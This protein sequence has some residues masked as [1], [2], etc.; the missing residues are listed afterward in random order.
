MSLPGQLY[1]Y[2]SVLALSAGAG[3]GVAGQAW[4]WGGRGVAGL[5]AER[6]GRVRRR[7]GTRA[8]VT[9]S[10]AQPMTP[11]AVAA[12]AWPPPRRCASRPARTAATPCI[13][14]IAME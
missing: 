11:I 2:S 4:R 13:A 14:I 12:S 8:T 3:G 7:P 1:N 10:D 9:A 6:P 5:T